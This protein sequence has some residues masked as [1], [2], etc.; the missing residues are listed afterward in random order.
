MVEESRVDLYR[1]KIDETFQPEMKSLDELRD[2]IG[3]PLRIHD[4]VLIS[5]R[6]GR[7][8]KRP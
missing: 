6:R 1:K 8:A 3:W 2:M 4:C 7:R 5:P